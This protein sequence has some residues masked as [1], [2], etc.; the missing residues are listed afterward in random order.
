MPEQLDDICATGG[1]NPTSFGWTH[2]VNLRSIMDCFDKQQSQPPA[3]EES[4]TRT[5]RAGS[6][7]RRVGFT[8][9]HQNPVSD[10]FLP[11]RPKPRQGRVGHPQATT[12]NAN[13][14]VDKDFPGSFNSTSGI[15]LD[16]SHRDSSEE[17]PLPAT[18]KRSVFEAD[19]YSSEEAPTSAAIQQSAPIDLTGA[20][21]TAPLIVKRK[22]KRLKELSV[23]A[24]EEPRPRTEFERRLALKRAA[25]RLSQVKAQEYAAMDRLVSS[26]A[27]LQRM[28]GIFAEDQ[29]MSR[30]IMSSHRHPQNLLDVGLRTSPALGPERPFLLDLTFSDVTNTVSC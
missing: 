9:S 20:D 21:G 15:D 28:F 24:I 14:P 12:K 16:R 2:H 4:T 18:L 26:R 25:I 1:W 7:I 23:V 13:R 11:T 8:S 6:H 10:S 22:R 29:P 19:R 5:S 27:R 17:I 3:E 30:Q